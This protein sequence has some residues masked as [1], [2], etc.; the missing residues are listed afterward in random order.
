[1]SNI[2]LF[3]HQIDAFVK[4]NNLQSADAILVKK[5]VPLN[6]LDHYIIYLG[7]HRLKHLFMAN[8]LSG[9]KLYNYPELLQEMQTFQPEKIEKF[10]GTEYDRRQAVQR[11][12][13]KKDEKSYH[14]IL[15]NCEH[16]K[17]WVQKGIH[18]STQVRTWGKAGVVAGA[19]TLLASKSNTAKWI[20][21]GVLLAGGLAWALGGEEEK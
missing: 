9:V 1:M 18:D 19:A 21:L 7:M 14:L 10:V 11:A 13:A 15:N 2:K 4:A 20:G 3:E 12:V 6:L 17:N 8:T 5:N 16:F